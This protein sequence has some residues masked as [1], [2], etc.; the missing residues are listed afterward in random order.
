[1]KCKITKNNLVFSGDPKTNPHKFTMQIFDAK[2]FIL[3]QFEIIVEMDV[4][5]SGIDNCLF[6][7]L[8]R[9]FFFKK[10]IKWIVIFLRIAKW[11]KIIGSWGL[12][13]IR[14]KW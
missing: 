4:S 6:Y 12:K 2:G 1:M 11:R 3:K 8:K 13:S 10:L 5:D 14:D 7:F 9:K